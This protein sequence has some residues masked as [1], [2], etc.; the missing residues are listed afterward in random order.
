MYVLASRPSVCA[1]DS[2]STH[3][4]QALQNEKYST[5]KHLKVPENVTKICELCKNG[6]TPSCLTAKILAAQNIW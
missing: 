3:L 2:C 4:S 1:F 6:V 5:Q